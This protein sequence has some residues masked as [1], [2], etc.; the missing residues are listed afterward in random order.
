MKARCEENG[1]V[2]A[3]EGRIVVEAAGFSR[4][5]KLR[6]LMINHVRLRG[7]YG[8]MPKR[9]K[10]LQW[11]RCPLKSLPPDFHLKEVAALDLSYSDI[12]DG[13]IEVQS[14]QEFAQRDEV[15][16][17]EIGFTTSSCV[18]L[19]LS[20]TYLPFLFPVSLRKRLLDKEE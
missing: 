8:S 3:D 9:I 13:I 14:E 5:N 11:K 6:L 10:W 2:I 4:M 16:S 7:G 20:L 17:H 19:S 15:S 12:S 1:E 18:I